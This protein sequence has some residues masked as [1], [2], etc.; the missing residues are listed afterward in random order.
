MTVNPSGWRPSAPAN[1]QG[2]EQT[3][4]AEA[5]A[6]ESCPERF[7]KAVVGGDGA[8]QEEPGDEHER[9]PRLAG[10]G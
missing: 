9:R 4:R 1:E 3:A 5:G 10:R 7:E 8:N 6:G 2:E